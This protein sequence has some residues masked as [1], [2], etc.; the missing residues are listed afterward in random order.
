MQAKDEW[1]VVKYSGEIDVNVIEN[2][3]TDVYLTL[4]PTNNGTGIIRIFVNWGTN[5][6]TQWID[7]FDNPVV[8]PGNSIFENKGVSQAKIYFKRLQ[9][10]DVVCWCIEWLCLNIIC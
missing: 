10:F 8:S 9:I 1:N 6:S 2:A 4:I 7:Y 3:V 5:N